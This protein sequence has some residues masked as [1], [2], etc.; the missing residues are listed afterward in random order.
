MRH[1]SRGCLW[2]SDH[3]EIAAH[4]VVSVQQTPG[5]GVPGTWVSVVGWN[6]DFRLCPTSFCCHAAVS[7]P[8]SSDECHW[9]ALHCSHFHYVTIQSWVPSVAWVFYK[10]PHHGLVG[11][12][13]IHHFSAPFIQTVDIS[14]SIISLARK[15]RPYSVAFEYPPSGCQPVLETKAGP[16][17][18][19]WQLLVRTRNFLH[20]S[21]Q[22][23]V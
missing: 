22:I 23:N 17:V 2:G 16:S 5:D 3:E 14:V 12:W 21:L 10:S 8:L 4:E 6:R 19:D 9:F 18:W 15:A 7:A 11:F 1:F 20:I 13:W